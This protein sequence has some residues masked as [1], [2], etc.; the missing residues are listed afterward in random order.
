[1]YSN[2]CDTIKSIFYDFPDHYYII[3]GDFN[4]NSFDW[5]VDPNIQQHTSGNMLF[6]CYIIFLNFRQM[7]STQNHIGKIVV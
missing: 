3:T 5:S 2:H 7:N 6:N 4:L 1:M